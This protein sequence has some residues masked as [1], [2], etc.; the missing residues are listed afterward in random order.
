MLRLRCA[1]RAAPAHGLRASRSS[2][3]CAPY[4]HRTRLPGN[5]A[6]ASPRRW[7]ATEQKETS[8]ALTKDHDYDGDVTDAPPH[9]IEKLVEPGKEVVPEKPLTGIWVNS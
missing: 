9:A 6:N 4:H 2:P 7:Y 3:P 8:P 5:K 1:R